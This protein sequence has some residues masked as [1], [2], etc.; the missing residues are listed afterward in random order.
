MRPARRPRYCR[1]TP[2]RTCALLRSGSPSGS[3][4]GRSWW[5][6][7]GRPSRPAP[8]LTLF[9]HHQLHIGPTARGGLR[10]FRSAL[11]VALIHELLRNSYGRLGFVKFEDQH[12]TGLRNHRLGPSN[13]VDP[14]LNAL[15][16]E[17]PTSGHGYV[18]IA[19]DVKGRRNANHTG[20]RREAP[21]LLSCARIE[22]PELPVGRSS[23]ENEVPARH[24]KRRPE[25]GLE[26]VLPDAL[27]RIQIPGFKLAK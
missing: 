17:S 11:Q 20:G 24:Q 19:I 4:C 26:I 22:C 27:A 14:I 5:H 25:D 21:K 1:T 10:H 23:R 18:L 9:R 15:R 8:P 3:S 6:S 16:V 13:L 12:G 7:A 2:R